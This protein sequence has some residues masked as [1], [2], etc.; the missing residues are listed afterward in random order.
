MLCNCPTHELTA[1]LG[2]GASPLEPKREL[3][4][5]LQPSRNWPMHQKACYVHQE[6]N[7]VIKLGSRY[8]LSGRNGV[9]K[10]TL[11]KAIAHR[12]N[13]LE[14]FPEDVTTYLFDQELRCM[15][16]AREEEAV[17]SYVMRRAMRR[18]EALRAE[19]AELERSGSMRSEEDAM[20]A[21]EACER[22]CEI[23]DLLD[24]LEG[25]AVSREEEVRVLLK[26]L[27]FRGGKE[28]ATISSL[29]GGW[30][31]RV[32]L[33]CALIERPQILLLDEPTNHLDLRATTW[34]EKFLIKR[35]RGESLIF[36]THDR[37]FAEV[38]ATDIIE[39]ADQRLAYANMGLAKFEEA[40]AKRATSTAVMQKNL[41][42]KKK[43]L[44][45]QIRKQAELA[46]GSGSEKAGNRVAALS[47]KL[48]R[49]GLEKTADGKKWNAQKHGV[50]I[51]ADNNNDGGWIKG[52]NGKKRMSAATHA[53][54]NP[55]LGFGFKQADETSDDEGEKV[56]EL[57]RPSFRYGD[58]Q[59]S[60][61]VLSAGEFGIHQKCRIAIC[62]ENGQGKTTLLKLLLGDLKPT[63]GE[64][65]RMQGWRLFFMN[66]QSSEI[67]S[68]LS[69]N[70]VELLMKETTKGVPELRQHLGRFGII[71][72]EAL[73]PLKE[74]SGG[75]RVRVAM[76]AGALRDPHLLVL[77]EPT[78]HL[79]MESI[80]ALGEALANFDGGVVIC[81]HDRALIKSVARDILLVEAGKAGIFQGTPEQYLNK[82]K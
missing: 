31:A 69:I 79:D 4:A 73:R 5:L 65:K 35:Y 27:G 52:R 62:G 43:A 10:S 8:F 12:D 74:L 37:A 2:N 68:E 20:D 45:K 11:L 55:Q 61:F 50:R 76:S 66:Q 77:D 17:A 60:A 13:G 16:D 22:L 59:S 71:G 15:S 63:R 30:R 32:G 18:L 3:K 47:K 28:N 67:L 80:E 38:V 6:Q 39:M 70:P 48:G 24:D 81:T 49:T 42:S 78:N 41:D 72:A 29:S 46:A 75:Q 7:L 9:G 53:K 64:V 82:F 34:L 23:Y 57:R 19:A 1:G 40:K 58:P 54:K 56:F 33:A 25:E 51:G 26:G 44:E 21:E 36:V 14:E